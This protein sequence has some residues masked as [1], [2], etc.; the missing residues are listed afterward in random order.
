MTTLLMLGIASVGCGLIAERNRKVSDLLLAVGAIYL[1][2][3]IML[4]LLP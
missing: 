2:A 4:L 3:V 1:M